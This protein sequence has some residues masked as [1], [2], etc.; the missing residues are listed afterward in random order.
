[1]LG[2]RKVTL[3]NDS[4]SGRAPLSA[5]PS[6]AEVREQLEGILT[7]PVFAPS[8]RLSRFLRW[9]VERTLEGDTNVLKEYSL[10]QDV[11]DR[12]ESFDPKIDSIVRVEAQRL[13]KK[14]RQY[15]AGHGKNDPLVI[16]FSNKGYVPVFRLARMAHEA[17]SGL[18]PFTVAVLPF[19]SL[20]EDPGG[21]FLCEGIAE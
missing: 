7:S 14:L 17:F 13:R 16:E 10:G 6:G 5:E 8:R 3:L 19:R 15:Y 1:M 12:R 9:T 21:A 18:D 20:T 4:T 11:F 2:L